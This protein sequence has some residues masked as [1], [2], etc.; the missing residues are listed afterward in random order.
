M[1]G[2]AII[3]DFVP[4]YHRRK[5]TTRD[6]WSELDPFSDFSGLDHHD[7]ENR[8][9]ESNSKTTSPKPKQIN[10]GTSERTRKNKY[11]GIRQRPW[12]K[13]A[14]EIRDPQK[15]VRVWLGTYNS[16]EEAAQAYDA[17]A[18]RIRG[19]KAKLNFPIPPPVKKRCVVPES[20]RVTQQSTQFTYARF[21]FNERIS[22]LE[23][24]LGLD[25]EPTQFGD[26]VS[27]TRWIW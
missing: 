14:A 27:P 16:A 12:G 21:E 10:K 20:T 6:V 4:D 24:F 9:N 26:S 23:S 2:G 8:P 13:W 11:R 1:C 7:N 5:L 22:D 15:G 18:T 17:A 25:S 3:S 19:G